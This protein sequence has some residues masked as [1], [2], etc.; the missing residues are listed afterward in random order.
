MPGLARERKQVLSELSRLV[1]QARK[2]SAPM[3]EEGNR[4]PEMSS[5]LHMSTKL[6]DNVRRF[7]EVAV[8]CGV[9]LPER[10]ASQGGGVTSDED[11]VDDVG[12]DGLS[13]EAAYGDVD[14]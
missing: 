10:R 12:Y 9:E 8:G 2:A 7:L 11:E 4:A 5:M 13:G 3:T 14:G 1:A 6:L